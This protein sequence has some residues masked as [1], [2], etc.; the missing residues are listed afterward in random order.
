MAEEAKI[1]V[2]LDL[3]GANSDLADLYRQMSNAPS[4]RGASAGA[5]GGGGGGLFGMS[6]GRLGGLAGTGFIGAHILGPTIGTA[7]GLAASHLDPMGSG[8]ERLLFGQTGPVTTASKRAIAEVQSALGLAQGFMDEKDFR[9]AG[10]MYDALMQVYRT[11]EIGKARIGAAGL[12]WTKK[13]VA[14]AQLEG[15]GGVV[16][17]LVT[18]MSEVVVKITELIDNLN[19]K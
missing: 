8:L 18:K 13:A 7:A 11:E 6:F 3:S 12:E 9:A 2:R 1:R 14:E 16:G 10:S 5:A 17:G 15:E 4:V 19:R